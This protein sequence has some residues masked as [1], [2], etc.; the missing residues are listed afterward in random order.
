M[1]LRSVFEV[2]R[3]TAA[4]VHASSAV[5]LTVLAQLLGLDFV[6]NPASRLLYYSRTNA[7][8]DA[9]TITTNETITFKGD[10][11]K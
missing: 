10:A 1:N 5:T 9:M 6:A 2:L 7:S 3:P 4:K 11:K 8:I